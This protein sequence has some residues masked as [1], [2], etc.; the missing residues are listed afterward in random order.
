V[1]AVGSRY[2]AALHVIATLR[3]LVLVLPLFLLTA[4][5]YDTERP[6]IVLV[7]I[8]TLRADHLG[9]Y[10]YGKDTSPFLD[11]LAQRGAT[12]E[13]AIVPLPATGPSH[14]SLL[15]GLEPW[16]HGIVSNGLKMTGRP[17]TLA[18]S[19][20]RAGYHTIGQVAIQFLSGAKGFQHGF[21][22][23]GQ[24]SD[25]TELALPASVINARVRA[26]VDGYL[27]AGKKQPLFL[28]VHYFD[29]H[30]PYGWW[31]P[32][33]PEVNASFTA[34]AM[35]DRAKLTRRY[36]DGIR[37]TDAAVKELYDYLARK[38]LTGNMIF[39]VTSD[40]GEQI[41]DHGTDLGHRDLYRETVRVPLIMT[42][43]GIPRRRVQENVSTMDVGVTLARMAG[44]RW[45]NPTWG[46]DL[47]PAIDR[48]SAILGWLAPSAPKREFLVFG[49]PHYTR[50][51]AYIEKSLWFIKNFDYVY[52][53]AW[54]F[55]PAPADGLE[56]RRVPVAERNDD[57]VT[58][59][60]PYR[61]YQPF[62][63]TIEHVGRAGPCP[64]TAQLKILPETTYFREPVP[65]S[66]S[67][68]MVVSAARFDALALEIRPAKCAGE[69]RYTV[70]RRSEAS[71]RAG[72]RP[73]MTWLH[74][75]L[76]S[77]RDRTA[78]ELY[79]VSSDPGM[80]RNIVDDGRMIE[81]DRALA[82]RLRTMAAVV[83][84][85]QRIRPEDERRLRSLGYIQ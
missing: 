19:L 66:G 15:T 45:K 11:S 78:D 29:C 42:G 85:N 9:A 62:E 63:A 79:D 35:K 74:W 1:A 70:G 16:K 69:T 64:A 65:F 17:D 61:R 33:D 39:V 68:R 38:R 60:I 49:T 6:V 18:A 81:R 47:R 5:A 55:Q 43:P 26:A 37:H 83:V 56:G 21:D 84:E 14:A 32:D 51:I 52:R 22:R 12:F 30:T 7:S 77:R 27:A 71:D 2:N 44:A 73:T 13:Q 41:G 20:Q 3:R 54:L 80:V 59:R 4:A 28:F 34:E 23:F 57:A 67:I 50:S 36:D 72:V 76:V 75:W 40:H 25:S 31:N 8:D 48:A 24:P 58:Y 82:A 10:G 46:R 53:D